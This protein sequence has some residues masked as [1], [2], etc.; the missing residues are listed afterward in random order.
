MKS[1]VEV[2]EVMGLRAR[3]EIVRGRIV[4]NIVENWYALRLWGMV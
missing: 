1:L 2:G 3:V 4:R